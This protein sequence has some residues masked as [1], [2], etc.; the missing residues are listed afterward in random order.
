MTRRS[1]STVLAIL[2]LIATSAACAA[3]AT[4]VQIEV[5]F[6][7]GYVE[8]SGCEFQRN[9]SWYSSPQAQAHLRD[10]FKYLAA[11][12]LIQT[13]EQFIEKAASESSLSGTAYMVRCNGGPTMTSSQWLRNE[14]ARLRKLQ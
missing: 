1:M 6:L 9:G 10:K 2:G 13:T 11:R 5:S 8:G 3:P 4:S 14:L 12:D 7:L